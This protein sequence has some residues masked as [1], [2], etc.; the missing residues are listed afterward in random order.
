MTWNSIV[1]GDTTAYVK[2]MITALSAP[3]NRVE[4]SIET[5]EED[6]MCRLIWVYNSAA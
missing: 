1:D 4:Q 3:D 6:P 2:S 5:Q